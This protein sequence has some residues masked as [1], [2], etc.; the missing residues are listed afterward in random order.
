LQE[1][2]LDIEKKLEELDENHMSEELK[3]KRGFLPD[4]NLK[5]STPQ[6]I[7]DIH[8]IISLDE[9]NALSIKYALKIIKNEASPSRELKF[10]TDFVYEKLVKFNEIFEKKPKGK[11]INVMFK[12]KVLLYLDFLLKVYK[13]RS[14]HKP[15][16]VVAR[17]LNVKPIFLQNI[18]NKFYQ[19]TP[20]QNLENNGFKYHRVNDDKMI[21]Y[22][23]VLCLFFFDFQMEARGLS[24]YL[25]V[26]AKRSF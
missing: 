4:F 8:S 14:Y 19:M 18:L 25:K 21:C 22:I 2:A 3:G 26:D 20:V 5:A 13:N 17:D 23:I 15:V 6:K 9:W 16:E 11:N 10:Y 24:Q 1:K 12:L 7:Y